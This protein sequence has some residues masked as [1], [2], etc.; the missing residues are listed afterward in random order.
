MAGA[1]DMQDVALR[2]PQHTKPISAETFHQLQTKLRAAA[3]TAGGVNFKKLF[4]H[5][6]RDNSGALDFVEFRSA[7]RRDAKIAPGMMDD[8][9]LASIF[10]A[11]DDDGSGEV[12]VDEFVEWISQDSPHGVAP[13]RPKSTPKSDTAIRKGP[14]LRQTALLDASAIVPKHPS[15]I[16]DDTMALFRRK[17]KAAAYTAGGI[18]V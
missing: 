9:T 12:D 18:N 5:Y 8:M 17:L 15:P 16:P 11:V 2:V 4:A 1:P 7:L 13:R 10:A 6:D 14:S 3:Y